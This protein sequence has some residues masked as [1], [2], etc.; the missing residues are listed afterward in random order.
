MAG[1]FTA[2]FAALLGAGFFLAATF[3]GA[4]VFADL[5]G[6]DRAGEFFAATF[7]LPESRDALPFLLTVA[8]SSPDQQRGCREMLRRID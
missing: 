6:T 7:L 4:V 8:M 3:C 2:D 5:A 1:F